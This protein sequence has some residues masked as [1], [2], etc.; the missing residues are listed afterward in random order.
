MPSSLSS[1][2][3]FFCAYIPATPPLR[4]ARITVILSLVSMTLLLLRYNHIPLHQSSNFVWS[5]LNHLRFRTMLFGM[6]VCMF[7]FVASAGAA[8]ISISVF[9]YSLEAFSVICKDPSHSNN[10]FILFIL[11]ELILVS[12]CSLYYM[13]FVQQ[14]TLSSFVCGFCPLYLSCKVSLSTLYQILWP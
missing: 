4:W 6:T 13:F 2:L 3:S 12:L 11:L 1:S 7:S 9:L 5:P 14:V 10:I 8:D